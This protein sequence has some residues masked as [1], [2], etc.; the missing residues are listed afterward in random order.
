VVH[1][2]ANFEVI[3]SRKDEMT[4]EGHAAY[5]QDMGGTFSGRCP[6]DYLSFNNSGGLADS[7]AALE[8][9]FTALLNESD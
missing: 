4:R 9:I 8:R 6:T 1:C 2:V 7:A 3:Q 5:D